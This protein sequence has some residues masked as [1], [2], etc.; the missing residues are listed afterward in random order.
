MPIN[1]ARFVTPAAAVRAP[2]DRSARLLVAAAV[3]TYGDWLT[4]V[5]LAVLLFRLTHQ[6]EAPAAYI[7][8]RVAPRVL[9]PSPG[10]FMADRF[11]PG[12][13]A[14]WCAP[15]TAPC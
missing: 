2:G 11:G 8:A 15:A 9:G 3:S 14:G 7:L 4:V 6:A 1:A 5:A 13:V 10:G 12:R